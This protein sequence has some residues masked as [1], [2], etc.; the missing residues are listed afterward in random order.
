MDFF[1]L[2]QPIPANVFS[3]SLAHQ[4]PMAPMKSYRPLS[5]LCYLYRNS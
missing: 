1:F 4:G 3:K 5:A 2:K